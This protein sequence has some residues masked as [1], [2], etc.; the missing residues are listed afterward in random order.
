MDLCG[1][2]LERNVFIKS[3]LP[4]LPLFVSGVMLL[5]CLCTSSE[6]QHL[7]AWNIRLAFYC[8]CSR[9]AC[10]E[11]WVRARSALHSE[12]TPGVVPHIFQDVQKDMPP[13]VVFGM[14]PNGF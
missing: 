2:R 12:F 4:W 14:S 1:F 13:F 8:P 3:A 5:F 11:C 9:Y 6:R 7:T 10:L